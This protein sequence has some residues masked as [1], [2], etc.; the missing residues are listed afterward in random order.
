HEPL[1]R[2]D[3]VLRIGHRLTLGHLADQSLTVLRET[4][5]R[6]RRTSPLRIR[7]HHRVAT[8]HHRYD[9]VRGPQVDTD[10]FIG[11]CI[12][13]LR[14][15]ESTA[16]AASL[17]P[18]IYASLAGEQRGW[19]GWFGLSSAQTPASCCSDVPMSDPDA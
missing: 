16:G 11:H 17:R 1:D 9:G 8:L 15:R 19:S 10:H 12:L 13:K 6:G 5:D 2:K 3:R 4:N 18:G 7:D 14:V